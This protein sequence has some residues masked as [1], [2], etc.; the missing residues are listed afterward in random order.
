MKIAYCDC[1]S[2]I[3]GDM[4]LGALLD[5]GLSLDSLKQMI[6]SLP[7]DE[8]VTLH[9]ESVHKGPLRASLLG[10]QVEPHE[11]HQ[12]RHLADIV[13]LIEASQLTS[14][15]KATSRAIF[16]KLAEAEA[17]VHGEPI[18]HIHFHEVGAVDSIVDILGA[19]I[20]L[21]ALGIERLYASALPMV[22][23]QVQTQ[24]GL[25]PLPAP[26]T[27]EL[28]RAAQM[29][30]TPSPAQVELVT[31]TG[32]AI[33]AT[34]A[35]FQQPAMSVSGVGIGAGR[36]DLP[37]PNVMRLIVGESTAMLSTDA[38]S[39][40]QSQ[41]VQM[42]TNIDDMNPQVFGYVMGQLFAAGALDV[43]FTSIQ[44]K[45]DRPGTMLGVIARRSDEAALAQIILSETSTLG[46]RVLPISH[47][48]EAQRE[49]RVVATDYGDIRVKLK[50]LDGQIVQAAPEYD[51]CARI[52]A[53]RRVPLVSVYTAAVAAARA[54]LG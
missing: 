40:S 25:L 11:S 2:G 14:I 42:E 50:Q 37:W 15:A 46:V 10:V 49:M 39:A 52:A 29:P 38:P 5:A 26:A 19:A 16:Q 51:D 6:A 36:R 43:Y 34:L 28:M 13:E 22:S 12:H 20:G 33:L 54:C 27:L 47:R 1:F 23:G 35:T 32:A 9:V 30:V 44:M 21:E 4:F 18:E 48:Y 17:R 53:E 24:H 41:L 45:K 31:P 8:H 3:S 7:L